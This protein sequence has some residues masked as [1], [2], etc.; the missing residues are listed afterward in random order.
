MAKNKILAPEK[1]KE[2]AKRYA[3]RYGHHYSI[4]MIPTVTEVINGIAVTRPGKTIEFKNGIYET[5]DSQEQEFLDNSPFVGID[6]QEVTKEVTS[7]LVTKSLA[8]REAELKAKEEE[9]KR[10]EMSIQGKEEGAGLSIGD[11]AV[12]KEKSKNKQAKF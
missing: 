5:K 6:Y 8:E 11:V 3:T 7:A 1:L 12:T 10:R 9:I 4:V 2:K